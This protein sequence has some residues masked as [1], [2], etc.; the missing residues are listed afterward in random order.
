MSNEMKD[1]ENDR[2]QI[3]EW[4]SQLAQRYPF[5][6]IESDRAKFKENLNTELDATQLDFMPDICRELFGIQL[7]ED[8]RAALLDWGLLNIVY[9]ADIKEKNGELRIYWFCDIFMNEE[10]EQYRIFNNCFEKIEK[11]L[12]P[13]KEISK[14]LFSKLY[15]EE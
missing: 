10:V 6:V 13:Y 2:A 12:T 5:L 3:L 1:W 7:C 8:L 9:I 11:V 15:A 4:N 14:E